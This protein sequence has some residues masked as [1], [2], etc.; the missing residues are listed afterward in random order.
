MRIDEVMTRNLITVTPSTGLEEAAPLFAEHP[1]S[2]LPVVEDGRLVGVLSESDIVAKETSGYSDDD[3]SEA[4]AKHLRR[5][6]RAVTV[7]EAMT[8]DPVTIEP[9]NSLW[10]AADRMVVHDVNRLPVVEA[11][12]RLVGIVTRDDLV[13]ACARSDAEVARNIRE[14][15]L[16]SVGLTSDALD[17][18]VSEGIVTVT[19][20]IES[21][22]ACSCLRATVHLVPG[23]VQVDWQVATPAAV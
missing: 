7:R 23:V 19:G 9:W 2:G 4:E 14:Q 1:I 16:P 17:I 3:V 12:G 6:R 18:S 10:A 8:A 20:E 11:H 5:E 13:R 21:E 15:L 22:M